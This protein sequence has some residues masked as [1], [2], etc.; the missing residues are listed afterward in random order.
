MNYR[1]IGRFRLVALLLIL[2]CAFNITAFAADAPS[3]VILSWTDNTSTSMTVTWIDA[4]TATEGYIRYST[5]KAL[6]DAEQAAAERVPNASAMDEAGVRFTATLTGLAPGTTYWYS[7]GSGDVWSVEQ[8]FTT[9]ERNA[10]SFSFMFLGDVQ[11]T[12]SAAIDFAEWGK[13]IEAA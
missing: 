4:E 12:Q 6:T 7:V 11:V 13:L 5:D 2:I 8:S 10:D 1:K 9:A 3:R